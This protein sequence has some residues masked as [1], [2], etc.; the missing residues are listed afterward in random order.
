MDIINNNINNSI[1]TL[2][3]NK[4]KKSN[5]N[6]KVKKKKNRTRKNIRKKNRDILNLFNLEE[7]E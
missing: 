3:N 6:K 4:I 7:I 1:I 5:H 2:K